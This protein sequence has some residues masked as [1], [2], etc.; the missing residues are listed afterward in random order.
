[1]EEPITL[2]FK[3]DGVIPNNPDL[4]VV[5][6]PGAS[7]PAASPEDVRATV[8][9]NGWRGAWLYGVFG[10]HHYHAR[11]HEA[12]IVVAGEAR[13][14]LGGDGGKTVTVRRGDL[15]VLPAGTGHKCLKASTDFQVCSCYPA[16]QESPDL[17]REETERGDV[18]AT[19]RSVP[20]P[21]TDPIYGAD[22]PLLRVWHN[23]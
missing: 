3:D 17:S 4:P 7:D 5:I 8:L 11:A 1:M 2:R 20:L 19:I 23:V 21:T 13:L 12:L 22:G 14:L 15:L 10:Y 16:G 18:L 6:V 9:R